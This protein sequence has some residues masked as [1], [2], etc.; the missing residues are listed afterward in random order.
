MQKLWYLAVIGL[1]G[2]GSVHA[3][4]AQT[5]QSAAAPSSHS[6]VD[7]HASVSSS[8]VK[9]RMAMGQAPAKQNSTAGIMD[10]KAM[11]GSNR[12]SFATQKAMLSGSAKPVLMMRRSY[13]ATQARQT[14]T[15]ESKLILKSSN[16]LRANGKPEMPAK[17]SLERKTSSTILMPTKATKERFRRAVHAL[18]SA[19]AMAAVRPATTKSMLKIQPSN[20]TPAKGVSG[21][22]K[23]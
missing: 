13:L 3:A 2:C 6:N 22:S 11:I 18:R 9:S 8:A 5:P 10:A 4:Q 17:A 21:G 14:A 12:N 1:V 20:I 23:S 7:R 19:K 15:S 16:A